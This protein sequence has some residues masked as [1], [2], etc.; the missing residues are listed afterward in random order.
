MKIRFVPVIFPYLQENSVEKAYLI[1]Y[2]INNIKY[3]FDQ[4]SKLFR[5]IISRRERYRE[6][7]CP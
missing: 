6:Q 3:E 5:I 2:T 4:N 7:A 1:I